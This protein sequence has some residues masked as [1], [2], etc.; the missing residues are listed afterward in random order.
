MPGFKLQPNLIALRAFLG[1]EVF[2]FFSGQAY[3]FTAVALI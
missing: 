3:S 2:L 1:P